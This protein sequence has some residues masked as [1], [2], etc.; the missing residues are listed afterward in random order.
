MTKASLTAV[1]ALAQ[2]TYFLT[3]GIWPVLSRRTFEAV[4][5]PKTDFWLVR[6]MGGVLGTIGATLIHGALSRRP[7]SGLAL[8]GIGSAATLGVGDIVYSGKGRISKIYLVESVV[9]LAL[10]G[11]W[12][13][14]LTLDEQTPR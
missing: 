5:G 8:L 12:V 6:I 11:M 1:P 13:A 9:E 4:T 14:A 10:I 3:T 2:G 7:S